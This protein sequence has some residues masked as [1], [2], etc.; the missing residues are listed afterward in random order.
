MFV[1]ILIKCS[2]CLV[3]L[4]YRFNKNVDIKDLK[5]HVAISFSFP[6]CAQ[7]CENKGKA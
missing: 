3:K 7:P 6:R 5:N 4:Y 2:I 1:V